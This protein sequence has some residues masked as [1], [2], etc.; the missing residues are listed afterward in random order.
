MFLFLLGQNNS[1]SPLK[2]SSISLNQI[3]G[4][5]RVESRRSRRKF[6]K[7]LE[8][9]PVKFSSNYLSKY[10]TLL[11]DMRRLFKRSL[12][13]DLIIQ[14]PID[15]NEIES[16][17]ESHLIN[18]STT[19]IQLD[20]QK[21]E[22]NEMK[23]FKVHKLILSMRSEV[24]ETMLNNE[25]FQIETSNKMNNNIQIININDFNATIVEMFLNYLYTD[26]IEINY[27]HIRLFKN[28]INTIIKINDNDSRLCKQDEEYEE[29]NNFKYNTEYNGNQKVVE[30]ELCTYFLTELY[31]IG[32]KYCVYN[33]KETCEDELTKCI[34]IETIVELLIV[35]HLHNSVRLKRKCFEFL[36]RNMTKV[37]THPTW[38]NLEKN[39]PNI[40]AETFRVL[41]LLQN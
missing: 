5:N 35:S 27:K 11:Y 38:V 20:Y 29:N 19:K 23:Q 16:I 30:P 39:F 37:V 22:K 28:N 26:T 8:I 14:A 31:R 21:I 17:S 18:S 34:R 40:I 15:T 32:D 7:N 10:N 24:F 12:M 3:E 1:N 2:R 41:C 25:N 13:H 9:N 6:R 33:L 36:I 4:S